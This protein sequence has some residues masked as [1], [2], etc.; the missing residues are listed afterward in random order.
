MKWSTIEAL[1][2]LQSRLSSRG[3]RVKIMLL[4]SMGPIQGELDDITDSYEESVSSDDVHGV[5]VVSAVVHLRTDLWNMY[6]KKDDELYAHDSGAVVH[7]KNVSFRIGG[8]NVHAPHMG[9]FV[10]QIVGFSLLKSD[11]LH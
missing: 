1:R 6:S 3:Q 7:L 11:V 9:V 10:D 4:T 5:D 8:R 2:I